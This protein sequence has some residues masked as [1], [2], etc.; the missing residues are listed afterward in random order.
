MS[1]W[2]DIQKN[3]NSNFRNL[4]QERNERANPRRELTSEETKRLKKLKTI[5]DKLKRGENVQNRQLQTWLSEGE[6]AQVDIEWQEQLEIREELKDKPSELKRYE[7]KLKE[8][9]MMRNRSDA[10]H[11]KGKK[12]AAY[13]LDSKCESLCEDAL[14]ILQEIVA[15][16]ASLQIWFDRNLDFGLGSLIDASLGNLPRLVTSRSIEKLS[17]DSR[18]V[19]K[20]D[21]KI[22]VVERA[23]Y[24][25]GRDKAV[26]PKVI[27]LS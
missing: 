23:S 20:I 1:E 3:P 22:S 25:I 6:Y 13:K 18:L 14:E 24:S 8:A 16:D 10:Y 27:V 26:P 15:A 2:F 12:S 19:K 7:D 21:V 5:A 4:L 11:R 17:N 9:I